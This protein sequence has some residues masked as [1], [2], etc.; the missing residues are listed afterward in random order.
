MLAEFIQDLGT[1]GRSCF[2]FEDIEKLKTSSPGAIKA[3]LRRL[4]KRRDCHALSGFL[5]D[6]SPGIPDSWLPPQEQFIPD[7]MDYLGETIMRVF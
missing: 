7:L 1:K 4:Q 2:I 3:A 6:C 5:C